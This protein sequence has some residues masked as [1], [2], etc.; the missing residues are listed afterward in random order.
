MATG[1]ISL[2]G[3]GRG[4]VVT[5]VGC[6]ITGRVHGES[7]GVNRR[8]AIELTVVPAASL[9]LAVVTEAFFMFMIRAAAMNLRVFCS[10][11]EGTAFITSFQSEMT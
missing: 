9:A 2:V 5:S 8:V 4:P 1:I 6:N 3:R 7:V 10:S 11:L